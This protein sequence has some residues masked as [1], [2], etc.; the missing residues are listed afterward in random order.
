MGVNGDYYDSCNSLS[1]AIQIR[2][3]WASQWVCVYA[4]L[5]VQC[6]QTHLH[7]KCVFTP[8]FEK[9]VDILPRW[10][11]VRANLPS[12]TSLFYGSFYNMRVICD[13]CNSS[14]F[15]NATPQHKDPD[16]RQFLLFLFANQMWKS[17]PREIFFSER[18][19]KTNKKTMRWA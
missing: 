7:R 12:I 14:L 8:T 11:P 3:Q 13:E 15:L 9:L 10:Y 4:C 6:G 2:Q 16:Q 5:C 18:Q 19:K 17:K 1:Q